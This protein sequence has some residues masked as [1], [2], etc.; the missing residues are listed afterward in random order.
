MATTAA[1][2]RVLVTG[3]AGFIGTHTVRLLLQ[4]R[5]RVMVIDDLRHPCGE[6]VPKE[7]EL[8]V[9][10]M[11]SPQAIAAMVKFRPE[12]VIHLAA[13]GGVSRS[14]RDPA[15]DALNNVVGTVAVLRGAVDAG[16]PSIVF[17][18]S[19]GA[20][21]G[22]ARR[23]PSREGDHAQPLAPYGA[24]KLAG[25]G[26]LG[27]F[28]R[29]FGLHFTAMRYGNV[30]G[31]YQD[32]TGEAGMVAISCQRLLDG[33]PP[34][35]TGDGAQTRDFVFV[36]DV[37]RA[38]LLAIARPLN[39]PVNIGT[40]RGTSINDI[41]KTLIRLA[42]HTGESEPVPAR[43]GEVRANFLNP[44]RASSKLGWAAEVGI[45]DGLRQTLDS[46]RAR[47]AAGGPM[48]PVPN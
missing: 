22:R 38:N 24:A 9:A 34:R 44:G 42:G 35:V 10:D 15:S 7:V 23:L 36:E 3:G 31:P 32:G 14:L 5:S 39:G 12:A 29:T 28:H 4:A 37:A 48:G 25:E 19:G 6:P 41:A 13:Q 2:T 47:A 45:E 43:P 30:Y 27:M 33:L 46:F 16:R 17:A 21:Y 8:V 18:S 1:P 40:G 11:A 20:I 26:Y